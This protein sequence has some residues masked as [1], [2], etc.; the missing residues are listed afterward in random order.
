MA[1]ENIHRG[2]ERLRNF[3][4]PPQRA[5]DGFRLWPLHAQQAI[6]RRGVHDLHVV[7]HNVFLQPARNFFGQARFQIEQ[8]FVSQAKDVHVGFHFALGG[9]DGSV[10][11][12]ANLEFFYV[13]G[14]LPVQKPRAV[15]A[16]EAKA[17]AETQVQHARALMQ[18]VVF[19]QP[20]AVVIH[21]LRAGC[22][23]K[24]G[25]EAVVEF[26]QP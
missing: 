19:G 18:C 16:D 2:E 6:V 25:A 5:D 4:E 10:T 9:G 13:V 23:R 11:T 12:S 14:H 3:R 15:G 21:G 8:E 22:F 24:S 20:V 1:S 26:L 17:R 7:G